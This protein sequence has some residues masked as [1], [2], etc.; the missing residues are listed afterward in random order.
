MLL[1]QLQI[2]IHFVRR[3]KLLGVSN[4]INIPWDTGILYAMSE[5]RGD[6]AKK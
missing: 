5:A 3:K 6:L 4:K 1:A 2:H